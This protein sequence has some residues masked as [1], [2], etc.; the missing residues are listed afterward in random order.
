MEEGLHEIGDEVAVSL[1]PLPCLFVCLLLLL[2]QSPP[3]A[4]EPWQ[5]LQLFFQTTLTNISK[6]A[7]VQRFLEFCKG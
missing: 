7:G 5:S 4:L 3:V 2:L 1:S 6:D